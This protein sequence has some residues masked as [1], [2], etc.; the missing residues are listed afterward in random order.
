MKNLVPFLFS[1]QS[2]QITAFPEIEKK[3]RSIPSELFVE[4][5]K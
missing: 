3:K 1:F 2:S 4:L 5:S